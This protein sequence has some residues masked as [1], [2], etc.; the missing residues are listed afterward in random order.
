MPQNRCKKNSPATPRLAENRSRAR[1]GSQARVLRDPLPGI[2]LMGTP[3]GGA[4]APPPPYSSKAAREEGN[5][6]IRRSGQAYLT[7]RSICIGC[8]LSARQPGVAFLLIGHTCCGGTFDEARASTLD[9]RP[10]YQVRS[11]SLTL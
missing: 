1:G 5:K 9:R 2:W 4:G 3:G 6:E 11:I 8:E 10:V 7:K